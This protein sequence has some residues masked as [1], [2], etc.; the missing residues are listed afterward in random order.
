MRIIF[1]R[2]GFDSGSGGVPSPIIDGCPVSLPIPKTP[3]EPF[4]YTDIQ[5]PCA[6]NL[7]DISSDLTKE[8]FTGASHAHY[9][10]Q[11]PW[12]TGVASLGQ[13]GAAQSHLVNQGV[14]SGDLIVF[15][16]LFKDYD[17]P[18]H[19]ANSR[20]HHRIFGYLEIDRMEVIGPKGATTRWRQMGLPRAHPTPSVATCTP[21]LDR[22]QHSMR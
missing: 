15:F 9:D 11:L 12:D 8:R 2:K 1:S 7:G 19:N 6:G 5:H 21:D 4:R 10:P 17:A 22:N 18:K 13:D 14:S 20:P 3:Q 16:G